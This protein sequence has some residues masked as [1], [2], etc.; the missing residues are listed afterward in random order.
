MSKTEDNLN[1]FQKFDTEDVALDTSKDIKHD[2]VR[3]PK[4]ISSFPF[5]LTLLDSFC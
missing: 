4:S 5:F 2:T 1:P 3:I